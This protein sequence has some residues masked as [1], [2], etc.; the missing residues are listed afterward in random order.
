[1][2]IQFGTSFLFF[3]TAWVAITLSAFLTSS[4]AST[5]RLSGGILEV[6]RILGV[7]GPCW[8]PFVLLAFALGRRRV[9][10]R[11]LLVFVAMEAAAALGA[12]WLKFT[13][14]S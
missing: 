5:P 2:R 8:L 4:R 10:I 9:T 14:Y 6:L 11:I 7:F 1:M 3:A 13:Y 12:M